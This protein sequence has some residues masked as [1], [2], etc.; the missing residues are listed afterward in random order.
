MG[1]CFGKR[2]SPRN[3]RDNMNQLK[4]NSGPIIFL[5]G[6]PGI[7]KRELGRRL[8]SK[9]GFIMISTGDLLNQEIQNGSERGQKF[10]NMTKVGQ[11]VP[12]NDILPMVEEQ[13]MNQP[14]A[15]GF[16]IVGFPRDRTQATLFNK[17]VKRPSLVLHLQVKN[18]VLSERVKNATAKNDKNSEKL[19][20]EINSYMNTIS[21]TIQPNKKVTKEIDV[22]N[23]NKDEIFKAAFE[24]I[25]KL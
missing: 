1:M 3:N 11:S 8:S 19:S 22:Q 16:L 2:K 21:S 13:L 25:D 10:A 9:Y 12:A 7:G 4:E 6:A 20:N 15:V 23:K 5:V 18:D 17:E 14:N 24:E